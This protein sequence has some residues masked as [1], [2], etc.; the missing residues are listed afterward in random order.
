MFIMMHSIGSWNEIV[1]VD[2]KKQARIASLSGKKICFV[3]GSN[4]S[5]G[6]DS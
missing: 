1:L 2:L 4:L 3:G 6:L 5:Y